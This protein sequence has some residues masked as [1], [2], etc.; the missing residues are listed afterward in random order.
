MCLSV[1]GKE[2]DI[3]FPNSL[4]RARGAALPLSSVTRGAFPGVRGSE[5]GGT[6]WRRAAGGRGA[7]WWHGDT[8]SA[9][10]GR[11]CGFTRPLGPQ[12]PLCVSDCSLPFE[13]VGD[14]FRKGSDMDHGL[15]CSE[16]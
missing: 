8:S 5:V 13:G 11:R 7:N 14:E 15:L 6:A 1:Q 10:E 4:T 16:F 3:S 9:G 2:I 12:L